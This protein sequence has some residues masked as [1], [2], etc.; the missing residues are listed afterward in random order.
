[1]VIDAIWSLVFKGDT[2][3]VTPGKYKLLL[4][5]GFSVQLFK[6]TPLRTLYKKIFDDQMVGRGITLWSRN[7]GYKLLDHALKSWGVSP[8]VA[9][10]IFQTAV[11]PASGLGR[12]ELPGIAVGRSQIGWSFFPW[13]RR[14]NLFN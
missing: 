13:G 2:W 9:G 11:V 5:K 8:L 6:S 14:G 1:M 4:N 12:K 3:E 7:F 10:T